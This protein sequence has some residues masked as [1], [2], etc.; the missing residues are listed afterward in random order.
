MEKIQKIIVLGWTITILFFGI[1]FVP[2]KCGTGFFCDH[3]N[4]PVWITPI[5]HMNHDVVIDYQRWIV[6][7]ISVSLIAGVLFVV[8]GKQKKNHVPK[9]SE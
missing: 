8:F 2:F 6:E 7:L 4:V 5:K 3:Y 9:V 1:F